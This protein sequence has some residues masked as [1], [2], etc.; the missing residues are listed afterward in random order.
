MDAYDPFGDSRIV[1]RYEDWYRTTGKRAADQEKLLLRSL[2]NQFGQAHTI[3]DV[4]CGTGYFTNWYRQ[5]GL[6]PF[7]LDKSL[8]MINHAQEHHILDCCLGDAVRLPFL[9]YSFD[10]VS[11]ITVLEFVTDPVLALREA[12]R[13]TRRG[14]ILGVINRHSLLGIHYRLKD[15]PIWKAARF[16]TPG[17]LIKILREIAP[18]LLEI[19]YQT[20]LWPIFS[21]SSQLP[22]GGFIGLGVIV[23]L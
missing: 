15:G 8:S 14:L 19:T 18:G 22:W 1:S 11:L 13:V 9:P 16:F 7:G 21:G 20:T 6:Q 17:E 4:G 23:N 5:L 3:L 12:L 2:I 10:L